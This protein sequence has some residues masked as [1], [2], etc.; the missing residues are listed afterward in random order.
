MSVQN[1]I[2][3]IIEVFK[4]KDIVFLAEDHA[5]KDNLLFVKRLIPHLYDAGVSFLGMEFGASEDQE[6]LDRLVTGKIFDWHIARNLMFHYNVIFPYKEYMEL[7]EAV[8]HFNQ[9]LADDQTPFR[10]LNLSYVYDWS[11]Y[12]LPDTPKKRKKV[13][14]KGDIER[15]RYRI[16]KEQVIKA[17]KK[18]L[19]LTGTIHALTAYRFKHQENQF[20][21]QLVYDCHKEKTYSIYLHEYFRNESGQKISPCKGKVEAICRAYKDGAGFDL[22][23]HEI[24][25]FETF[26]T[27]KE[28]RERL[29]LRELFDGYIFLKSLKARKG[30][31]VDELF[32]EGHSL[33]DV[34]KQFPDPNWHEPPKTLTAYWQLVRDYVDLEKRR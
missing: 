31:T 30:C 7:Y 25:A 21:G 18:I 3:F 27:Y 11:N 15:Y 20:F 13:F 22:L 33:D 6:R 17:Q 34:L 14:H 4:T 12:T 32:L 26:S 24:G 28:D 23:Q 9:S 10:I 16:V 29:L 1:P 8:Y 19:I 2:D 5:V